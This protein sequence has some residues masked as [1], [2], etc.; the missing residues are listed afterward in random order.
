MMTEKIPRNPITAECTCRRASS[1][2]FFFLI[3]IPGGEPRRLLS[4]PAVSEGGVELTGYLMITCTEA[5]TLT[6]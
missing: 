3:H 1:S 4:C 6:C 2:F 5:P